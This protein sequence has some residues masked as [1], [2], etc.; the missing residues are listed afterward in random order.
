MLP[1]RRLTLL[2]SLPFP[3]SLFP[4]SC[5]LIPIPDTH[6]CSKHGLSLVPRPHP[7][8][9]VGSGNIHIF[10]P[11]AIFTFWPIKHSSS[12]TTQFDRL[13]RWPT[14]TMVTQA[15]QNGRGLKNVVNVARPYPTQWVWSGHET[16]LGRVWWHSLRGPYAILT[17]WPIKHLNSAATWFATQ[18]SG[19]GLGTRLSPCLLH[20]WVL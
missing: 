16:T 14:E 7:L 19:C 10:G 11:Y 5:F 12:A 3:I 9:W 17:F 18:R 20:M 8:H 6:I 1:I 13:R 15:Q 2:R 4:I